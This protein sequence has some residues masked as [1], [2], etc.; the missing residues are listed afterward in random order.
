M[1]RCLCLFCRNR[2][3]AWRKRCLP[4]SQISPWRLTMETRKMT[5]PVGCAL[6]APLTS[7]QIMHVRIHFV[8]S[9]FK[10]FLHQMN[11]C[12]WGI[13]YFVLAKLIANLTH[14][15]CGFTLLCKRVLI[16]LKHYQPRHMCKCKICSF[17]TS[18]EKGNGRTRMCLTNCFSYIHLWGSSIKSALKFASLCFLR[19]FVKLTN[20]PSSSFQPL[21]ITQTWSSPISSFPFL[22]S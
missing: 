18:P 6:T 22:W 2:Q 15:D 19:L 7:L 12:L 17:L 13:C 11:N 20:L 21:K 4:R 1:S 9:Q 8:F 5:T 3:T 14:A 10:L 16:I